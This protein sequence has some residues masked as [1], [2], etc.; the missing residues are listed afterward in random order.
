MQAIRIS[1]AKAGV[2]IF[3]AM[4]LVACGGGIGGGLIPLGTQM[5]GA[6]QGVVPPL[7]S[8][9]S[10]FAGSTSPGATDGSGTAASFHFPADIATD[11]INLFIADSANNTIRMIAISGGTVTTLAGTAG[12]S[13]STDA[14]GPAARFNN[15][16]GITTDGVN[17]YVADTNNNKIRQIV[18][19]TGVVTTLAGSGA[20]GSTDSTTGTTA[21]FTLPQGIT[22]D[23]TNVYV[24]DSGSNKIREIA[25]ASGAVS[26]LAGS[27]SPGNANGTGTAATFNQPQGITTDGTNL[28]VADTANN[29]IRQIVI[30]SQAVTTLA[31]SGSAV[32]ADGTGTAASFNLPQ[33]IT[34]DGTNLYVADTAN[35]T[36]RK[37]VIS[38]AAVT[39]PAGT[40]GSPG[41]SDGIGTAAQFNKP[42]GLTT[43]GISLYIADFLNNTIRKMR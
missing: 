25:I 1:A 4:L 42:T 29:T 5:G 33:G 13:G 32:S 23:G 36:I 26:T 15:P 35:N 38:S 11:G 19:S 31:G 9:V 22:T 28:Y 30:S 41:N 34:S 7:A 20:T 21:S 37:V 39:T 10:T 16:V 24:A 2:G 3:A 8:V 27:G 6:R 18:I 17:V 40:A 43:D 14:S 12:S